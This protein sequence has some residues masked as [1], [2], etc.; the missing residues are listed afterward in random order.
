MVAFL[1]PIALYPMRD[2]HEDGDGGW[3]QRY[4]APDERIAWARSGCTARQDLAIV[5]FG[6]GTTSPQA[7]PALEAAG[8]DARI[9]DMRWLS[10]LPEESANRSGRAGPTS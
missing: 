1:E 3:M 5:T 9:V 6:N 7:L 2:L 10:P 4:P 8:I